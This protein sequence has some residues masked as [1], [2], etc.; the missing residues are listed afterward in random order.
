M[1]YIYTFRIWFLIGGLFWSLTSLAQDL[2]RLLERAEQ[3]VENGSP[4]EAI[5]LYREILTYNNSFEAKKGLATC[6]RMVNSN[7]KAEYW[8]K[9]LLDKSP[10]NPDFQFYYAQ[11]LQKNGNCDEA[12]K[13]FKEFGKTDERGLEF[14]A[15][16]EDLSEFTKNEDK[17]ILLQMPFNTDLAEFGPTFFKDG[18]VFTG[19]GPVEGNNASIEKYTDLYFA[20][21]LSRDEYERP[22]KLRGKINGDFHDG[23][24]SFSPLEDEVWFTRTSSIKIK[25]SEEIRRNLTI[26]KAQLVDNKWGKVKEF[27]YNNPN[28]SVAHPSIS[29]DG[30]RLYF[31]SDMPDGEGGTDIYVSYLRDTT[32]SEPVNLGKEINTRGNELFPFI[33]PDGT[34]YFASDGHPGLGGVDIFY[35]KEE[36][37]EW[38]KPINFGSPVNSAGDDITFVIDDYKNTGYF[39]SNRYGGLGGDDLY[40]FEL[41]VPNPI[42]TT[43]STQSY[44]ETA[45]N[46]KDPLPELSTSAPPKLALMPGKIINESLEIS[47][48]EFEYKK[49]VLTPQAYTELQKLIGYLNENPESGLIIESHTDSREGKTTNQL[50]SDERA[51]NIYNFLVAMKISPERMFA[52]GYGEAYLLNDCDDNKNCSE[53]KHLVNDRIVFK[54][55]TNS[56]E[57]TKFGD[58]PEDSEFI[59][60]GTTLEKPNPITTKKEKVKKEKTKKEKEDKVEKPKK[61]KEGKVE[62]PKKEKE[63]KRERT[64]PINKEPKEKKEKEKT[65]KEKEPKQSDDSIV[66]L[67]EELPPPPKAKEVKS[68]KGMTYRIHTGPY[69][70]VSIDL[71]QAIQELK[72]TPKIQLKGAKEIIILGPFDTIAKSEEIKSYFEKRGFKS[73]IVPYYNG[74]PK[75]ISIQQLKK[76]GH[77]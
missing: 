17:Y 25:K 53:E 4:Q 59:E 63:N 57:E 52:Q 21:R 14:A 26:W 54:I 36:N 40:Y 77:Q 70:N 76:D 61:E 45:S 10:G 28:Y 6:Y 50:L 32:W 41:K 47:N 55:N 23:P 65:K 11:L 58:E 16:C 30:S 2:D 43:A 66:E 7:K 3:I 5:P 18:I 44:N 34:L 68:E 27:P 49:S 35:S 74:E 42:P 56:D 13:W 64:K 24:A 9:I 39:A 72:L 12:K 51:K 60:F 19:G 1:N 62:K 29:K 20:K 48:I 69:K 67:E 71:Q 38:Q 33:H 46:S 15:A 31:I 22:V 73:K 8:Y 75:K 37:R